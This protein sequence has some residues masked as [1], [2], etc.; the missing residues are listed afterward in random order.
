MRTFRYRKANLVVGRFL[1]LATSSRWAQIGFA[2][3]GVHCVF[4]SL[5]VFGPGRVWEVTYFR[6][7]RRSEG[8]PIQDMSLGPF[9]LHLDWRW[10]RH[11]KKLFWS[12]DG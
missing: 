6:Y 4:F 11:K 7:G 3:V 9:F 8:K 5:Y 2:W 12:S 10:W 1:T